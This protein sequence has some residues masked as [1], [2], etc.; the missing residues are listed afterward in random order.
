M[1]AG[2]QDKEG[3]TGAPPRR[4]VATLTQGTR[5]SAGKLQES[6]PH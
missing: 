2:S 3:T 6:G 4:E 5:A 1:E